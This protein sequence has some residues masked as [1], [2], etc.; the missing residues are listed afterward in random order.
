MAHAQ[1]PSS[2]RARRAASR[3]F[4]LLMALPAAAC[5]PDK[6]R[7]GIP[8][9]R[10][11]HF[12]NITHAQAVVGRAQGRFEAAMKGRATISWKTFNAGPSAIEAL[13]AG[14]LDLSYIGPNP[15]ITGYARSN[16]EALRIVA[17]SC[18]GGAALVVRR[19]LGIAKPADMAGRSLATPQL[20]NTQDV[21]ARHWLMENGL[22]WRERGG[23]VRILP[24][25]NP[26]QLTLFL[27][28]ELDA[29]WTV[30][31][32]VSRLTQEADGT[33]FLEESSLWPGG[34]YVTTHVI[35]A[36]RF[37]REH[38][39]L[40]RIWLQEHASITAWI[41]QRP[42]EAMAALN[43]E[44]HRLTGAPLPQAIMESSMARL[45]LTDDPLRESL[46][47]CARRAFALGFLG[48]TEPDLSGIHDLSILNE[49]RAAAG[50]PPVL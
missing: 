37:L 49:I 18:S 16:G 36:T 4:V 2:S 24:L 11:G 25:S 39:D 40:V 7:S 38:P 23:N 1:P 5:S 19:A 44:I 31:P 15:A 45:E 14:E 8:E 27:K 17:G 42:A 35:A 20:G 30:E 3:T 6:D 47:V 28:G 46:L 50:R 9:I 43:Q 13:F 33:V 22:S 21:A 10:A 26:D 29:A 41:G 34:R 12:P 48:K 32:W